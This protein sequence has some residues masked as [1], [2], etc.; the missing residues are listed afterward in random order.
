MTRTQQP[1]D[2]NDYAAAIVLAYEEEI[3]GEAFFQ[4]L[5]SF[6]SARQRQAMLLLAEVERLTA[7]SARPLIERHGLTTADPVA[8]H[9]QGKASAEALRGTSWDALIS[10]MVRNYP[11]FVLEFEQIER[12]APAADRVLTRVLIEHEVAAVEFAELEAAGDGQSL[13]PL[14]A[15]IAARRGE[16]NSGP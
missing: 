10:G 16:A 15:F 2:F 7:I 13:R 6:Y 5:A 14:E 4:H 12:L 3:S 1:R 11:A 9:I 8:L